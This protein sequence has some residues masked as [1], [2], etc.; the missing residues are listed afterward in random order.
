MLERLVA[1]GTLCLRALKKFRIDPHV[2]AVDCRIGVGEGHRVNY[3]MPILDS[4]MIHNL[5]KAL[6]ALLLT[7]L[8]A[9]VVKPTNQAWDWGCCCWRCQRSLCW[10]C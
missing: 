2:V 10:V 1:Y 9:P 8:L 6:L 7:G 3:M 4:R 5:V